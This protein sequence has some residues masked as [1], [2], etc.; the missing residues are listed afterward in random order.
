MAPEAHKTNSASFINSNLV[1]L[2]N[3]RQQPQFKQIQ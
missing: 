1:P 3:W 2:R